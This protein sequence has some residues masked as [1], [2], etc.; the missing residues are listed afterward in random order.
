MREFG[1]RLERRKG[2]VARMMIALPAPAGSHPDHPA[3]RLASTL[4]PWMWWALLALL[5]T[6]LLQLI[7]APVRELGTTAL[8]PQKAWFSASRSMASDSARRS[9]G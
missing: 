9:R 6:G 3:L 5:L 1:L 4:L 2:E 7:A 8:P